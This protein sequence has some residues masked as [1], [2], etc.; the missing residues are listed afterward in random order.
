MSQQRGR[1]SRADERRYLTAAAVAAVLMAVAIYAAGWRELPG[2]DSFELRGVFSTSNQVR[3]GNPVRRAGVEIGKVTGVEAGPENTSIVT[4][5]LDDHSHLHSNASLAIKPRLFFEG[6]FYIDVSAGTPAAPALADGTMI[7]LDRT[8]GPVQVDQ[9]LS[10][11]TEPVR[12]ALTGTID[13]LAAGL[14]GPKGRRGSDELRRAT[15]ELDAALVSVERTARAVQGTE[16]GDLHRAV[17]SAADLTE[18]L[19]RDPEALAGLVSD[20]DRVAVAL[21]ADPSSLSASVRSFNEVLRVAP[22]SLREIDAALPVVTRFA[23]DLRPGLRAAPAALDAT[24]GLLRQLQLAARPGELSSLVRDL[25]PLTANVP[26]LVPSLARGLD[27]LDKA[28]QCMNRVILPTLNTKIPDG[29]NS[30]FRPAWQDALHLGANLLGSSAGFDGN[31]GTL[32]LGLSEGVNALQEYIPGIGEV[33]GNGEFEGVNPI[34][35]GAG[36]SPEFRPDAW[37]KDQKLPDLGA[38]SRLGS[39]VNKVVI[40]KR[41]PSK[42]ELRRRSTVLDL[43]TGDK[44]DR[45]SLLRM[46]R[47]ELP[48]R[49]EPQNGGESAGKRPALKLPRPKPEGRQPQEPARPQSPATGLVDG[50][51]GGRGD[52]P[53]KA[54]VAEQLEQTVKGILSGI[55]G[56]KDAR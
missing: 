28:G 3:S 54:P 41:V 51:L 31:G 19:A 11:L 27:L 14:G 47:K 44:A 53:V 5:E 56:R 9:V 48:G 18:Q 32:R 30:T 20:F 33:I 17:G 37:C 2:G 10:T 24:T 38:R 6:N 23:R 39:P 15:R 42:A 22:A 55:L 35:L 52:G 25:E 36:V 13:Q 12:E 7:P 8:S 45:R 29:P 46:L 4:M 1:R 26:A 21:S 50:L 43:L 16:A 49:R 34:W 40:P